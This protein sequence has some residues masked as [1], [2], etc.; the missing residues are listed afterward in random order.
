[1]RNRIISAGL[2]ALLARAQRYSGTIPER[3]DMNSP[4]EMRQ[5]L[6][7]Y[8]NGEL[9][10]GRCIEADTKAGYV[11][12]YKLNKHGAKYLENGKPAM[13]RVEGKVEFRR[14]G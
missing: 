8:L 7:V 9:Q 14:K 2:I 11:V 6:D 5:G 4:I 10:Q 1:M 12:R 3:M 13:Q